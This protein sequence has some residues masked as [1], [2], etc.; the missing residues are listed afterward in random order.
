MSSRTGTLGSRPG[1]M[2]AASNSLKIT[3]YGRGG[4]ASMPNRTID[5][6][7]MAAQVVVRLQTIVSR[8]IDP[9]DMA[10][11]TVGSLQAGQTENIIADKAELR[12][13]VRTIT[14]DTKR[15]VLAS[16]ARI[17]KAEC[18]ASGTPNPPLIEETS[19][20]PVTIN[21]PATT[22]HLSASFAE[23]FPGFDPSIPRI[24]GSEDFS[25]LGTLVN[26][27]CSFWIFGG[28]DA[29]KWDEAERSGRLEEDIPVN[30]SGYFAPVVQP[31]MKTGVDALVVA[32]MTF[33]GKG[34]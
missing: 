23:H 33:F 12:I 34:W 10:V 24:N 22:K 3:L 29:E 1:I 16:I 13:N 18:E 5:P 26:R 14:S 11:V 17:V 7:V 15:K 32:A 9:N 20:F 28:T 27:P 31:T 21:D 4:H 19:A 6:V 8:E 25:L 30:H 2:L